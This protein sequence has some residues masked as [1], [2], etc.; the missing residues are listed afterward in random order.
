MSIL[1]LC[2]VSCVYFIIYMDGLLWFIYHNSAEILNYIKAQ[3]NAKGV[4]NSCDA[5][6]LC[7]CY[8]V[9]VIMSAIP[10][11]IDSDCL[12]TCLFRRRSKKISKL[13]ITGLCEGYSS[14]TG[15]FPAQRASNADSVSIFMR[16]HCVEHIHCLNIC[17]KCN[18]KYHSREL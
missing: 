2:F 10:S 5:L 6:W 18:E 1:F 14:V 13:R 11:Q 4:N 17:N 12:L 16:H 9:D 8:Y 7:Y 15:I 3:Q